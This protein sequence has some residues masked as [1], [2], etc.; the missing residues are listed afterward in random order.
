MSRATFGILLLVF[1][2]FGAIVLAYSVKKRRESDASVWFILLCFSNELWLICYAMFFLITDD[3]TAIMF[4]LMRYA[5]VSSA[6][7]FIYLFVLKMLT[8]KTH[9]K[10]L[11]T[12]LLCLPAVTFILC[13]TNSFHGLMYSS[14]DMTFNSIGLPIFDHTY[15]IWYY[16]HCVASYLFIVLT[17]WVL[18]SQ[19][20]RLPKKFG[21]LLTIALATV[22][23]PTLASVLPVMS[24][25]PGE[26]DATPAFSVVS[27]VIFYFAL[28]H[29]R[30]LDILFAS[31]ESIFESVGHPILVIN[32]DGI[33]VE[34]NS[35]ARRIAAGLG[36]G[37]LA[38]R[39]YDEFIRTWHTLCNGR[40]FGEDGSI[41]TVIE[42]GTD[43]HYQAQSTDIVNRSGMKIGRS[44]EI[45]NITPIMS[46]IHKLQDSAYFDNLT[47]LHNRNY[48]MMMIE[49]LD[50]PENLPLCVIVGD[51]N[52]LKMV[53][54]RYGHAMGDRL[55]QT[56][57]DTLVRSAP[58]K[59]F[60]ARIGGDEF[61]GLI[62][63]SSRK[64]AAALTIAAEQSLQFSEVP[65]FANAG[66]ALGYILKTEASQNISELISRADAEM[67]KKKNDR[68]RP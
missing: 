21:R 39:P 36:I 60:F 18:V 61:L 57:A 46:L 27:Q 32:G 11:I 38:E 37:M 9:E 20:G 3:G 44:I 51:I 56:V 68:R 52:G 28:F 40:V 14:F 13:L 19:L 15:G 59:A 10:S 63:N 48:S 41:F 12:A 16:I 6:G 64:E 53:N 29:A 55:L 66:I 34:Y 8:H 47:G 54:D 30:S 33:I 42:D 67:Y 62:P 45:K 2:A 22:I 50:V 26:F 23:I 35:H 25:M 49:Q 58:P 5:F 7:I 24:V 65:E 4:F 17:L 31:R 1:A 43:C